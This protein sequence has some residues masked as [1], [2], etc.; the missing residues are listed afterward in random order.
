MLNIS[1]AIYIMSYMALANLVAWASRGR[2]SRI[3]IISSRLGRYTDILGLLILF[4]VSRISIIRSKEPKFRL[5]NGGTIFITRS[6]KAVF[7]RA[8]L[9]FVLSQTSVSITLAL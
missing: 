8:I 5:S 3:T 6:E 4:M 2:F 7:V 1:R 9:L